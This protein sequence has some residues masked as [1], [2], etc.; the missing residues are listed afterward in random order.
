[1]ERGGWKRR[2][3]DLFLFEG[4]DRT[5]RCDWKSLCSYELMGSKASSQGW[6]PM[7]TLQELRDGR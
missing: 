6:R 2:E 4:Q 1:V 3:D 7:A 5:A